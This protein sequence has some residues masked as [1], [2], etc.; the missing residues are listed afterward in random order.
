M[1]GQYH[2]V[3]ATAVKTTLFLATPA[4]VFRLEGPALCVVQRPITWAASGARVCFS[5]LLRSS[6]LARP[7]SCSINNTRV[8]GRAELSVRP[9]CTWNPADWDAVCRN[10]V[11]LALLHAASQN[12][13]ILS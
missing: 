4:Q 5:I 9:V 13:G 11:Q 6:I 2:R 12:A 10:L 7:A 1:R 8:D 3:A